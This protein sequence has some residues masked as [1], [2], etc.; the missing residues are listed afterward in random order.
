MSGKPDNR[1]PKGAS[2]VW[3]TREFLSSDAWRSLGNGRRFVDF[4]LLEHLNN[5][6]KDNGRLKAPRRQLELFG[7]GAHQ[8]SNA[9]EEAERVGLVDCKR[10]GE[11]K[12]N[13][14]ALTWL[15]LHDGTPASDRWR[16]FH[17]P[18]L[19]PLNIHRPRQARP[20]SKNLAVRKQSAL[21][22]DKQ[23]DAKNLTV[24]KHSDG[25]ENLTAD[26]H[27]PSRDSYQEGGFSLDGEERERGA[28]VVP[29]RAR[30]GSPPVPSPEPATPGKTASACGPVA[31]EPRWPA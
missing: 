6:G 18:T 5:G 25:P 7:L 26:Q 21:T 31:R 16:A 30:P 14:Y 9:I 2:W 3:L 4:L 8:I 11:R 22:V 24:R 23:S 15:P 13:T 19:K 1:P 20:N 28:A 10:P 12:A 29:L 17:S 27:Y